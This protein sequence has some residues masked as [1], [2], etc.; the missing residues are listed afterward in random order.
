MNKLNSYRNTEMFIDETAFENVVCKMAAIWSRGNELKEVGM[1][2]VWEFPCDYSPTEN[3]T[4]LQSYLLYPPHNE[5]VGG[6]FGF[7]LSVRPSVHPTSR[8]RSVAPTVLVGSI[9][10]WHILSRNLKSCVA[11][12]VSCK[13]L[14]FE[15]SAIFKICNFDFVLFW[16]GI[17]CES[18][19]LTA[20]K[21]GANP[22]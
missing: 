22:R 15:F 4:P 13:I 12:K 17:W 7:T 2:S 10:Y 19:V 6:Y 5:V 3:N 9:S 1:L 16:L 20:G 21:K 8:V 11:C 14:K 18:L